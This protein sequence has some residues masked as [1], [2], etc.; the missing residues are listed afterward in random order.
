MNFSLKIGFSCIWFPPLIE[1]MGAALFDYV[2]FLIAS[3]LTA[4]KMWPSPSD[5]RVDIPN[6]FFGALS[7][8]PSFPLFTLQSLP[9]DNDRKTRGQNGFAIPFL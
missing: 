6:K 3:R 9:H 1:G 7:P 4:A 8:S 5:N 2:G